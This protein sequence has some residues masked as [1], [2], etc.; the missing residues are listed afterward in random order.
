M[1]PSLLCSS[2]VRVNGLMQLAVDATDKCKIWL[3]VIRPK[4]ID[5]WIHLDVFF[6]CVCSCRWGVRENVKTN[7]TT[8]PTMSPYFRSHIRF[9]TNVNSAETLQ[10]KYF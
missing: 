1:I 6:S 7:E 10:I 3:A 4:I 9:K 2:S 5:R 8:K